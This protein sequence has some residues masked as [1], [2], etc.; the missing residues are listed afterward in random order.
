[1]SAT[2][3]ENMEGS[4]CIHNTKISD[5]GYSN[6]CSNSKSQRSGSSKTHHSGSSGAGSSGCSGTGNTQPDTPA[7]SLHHAKDKDRKTKEKEQKTL[8][9]SSP[10]GVLVDETRCKAKPCPSTAM[11]VCLETEASGHH[12]DEPKDRLPIERT[13]DVLK[14]ETQTSQDSIR[15]TD[16]KQSPYCL[17]GPSPAACTAVLQDDGY[18]NLDCEELPAAIQVQS[19]DAITPSVAARPPNTED[20][21]RCIIS[22]HDG[23]V[24]FTTPSITHSL[25]FP[26][27]MW[28]GRSFIDFVHPKDRATFAS[29]IT[30]KMAVPLGALEDDSRQKCQLNSLYVMLRKYRG[31]KSAGFAVTGTAVNY[32]PYR[33][34]LTFREALEETS[35]IAQRT[36]RNILLIISATPVKSVYKM[37]NEK[38]KDKELKFST[39]HKPCGR[40]NYVDGSSVELLGY[41]PQDIIERS[42]MELYHPEDMPILKQAYEKV[43]LNG[44]TVGATFA[45]PPYRFL[46]QNDCY[47]IL[48]TEWTSFVN[49]WSRMLELIIG[50]HRVLEGPFNPDVFAPSEGDVNRE[51]FSNEQM[52]DRESIADDIL[53]LLKEP[54]AKPPDKVSQEV[55]KR[56]Q[57]LASLMDEIPAEVTKPELTLNLLKV[58]SELTFSEQDSVM[59]GEISPHHDYFDSKSSSETPPSYHQLNYNDNLYRF[60]NSHPIMNIEESLKIDSS[61]G[62]NTE[63]IDGQTNVSPNRQFSGSGEGSNDSSERNGR[64]PETTPPSSNG[65]D[66]SSS[67]QP[68]ALTEEMLCLHDEDM[69]KAMLKRHREA[70]TLAR[71]SEKKKGP[72]D[73]AQSSFVSHGLKRGLSNSWEGDNH[74][75]FKHQHNPNPTANGQ[76]QSLYISAPPNPTPLQTAPVAGP[77]A[78][79]VPTTGTIVAPQPTT[80]TYSVPRNGDQWQPFSVSLTTIQTSHRNTTASFVPSQNMLP[81]LY[82]IPTVPQSITPNP[83]GILPRI[84]TISIPYIPDMTYPQPMQL[85]QPSLYYSPMMYQAMPFQPITLPS[86][87]T[88]SSRNQQPQN[89]PPQPQPTAQPPT[90]SKCCQLNR[91]TDAT[92]TATVAN[93]GKQNDRVNNKQCSLYR[94]AVDQFTT[95]SKGSKKVFGSFTDISHTGENFHRTAD[96]EKLQ[97]AVIDDTRKVPVTHRQASEDADESTFSSLASSFLRTENTSESNCVGRKGSSEMIWESAQN[98]RRPEPPWMENVSQTTNWAYRYQISDRVAK[99]VLAADLVKLKGLKQPKLVNDQL[100]QLYLDLELQGLSVKLSLSEASQ[101]HSTSSSDDCDTVDPKKIAK[102]NMQYNKLQFIYEEN[103]PFPPSTIGA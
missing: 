46:A 74:K 80:L 56:C 6:S 20:G 99:D 88:N 103:A 19:P 68:P 1:M 63:T 83:G 44:Q 93:G 75:T 92:G 86:G 48:Q 96:E 36:G 98:S 43:M 40:L 54:I 61:G 3:T 53:Q 71:S 101:S 81:T 69:Q 67:F 8:I 13:D 38:L 89:Q 76:D 82:Y 79:K 102:R 10:V 84:N 45:S 41:L 14:E 11:T 22:M 5:S 42:I 9:D 66:F 85:Y 60:F 100:G 7:A 52:K 72:P 23:V 29:Q 15:R 95:V 37:P 70:R 97:N 31:L 35:D 59:L 32:E 25:G 2:G 30:S 17:P 34:V 57:L 12:L 87:L 47:I 28:I 77:S 78:T 94:T 4:E 58:N 55:I 49:P 21:F 27:N 39:I 64:M 51:N 18:H 33:L 26:K 16:T 50:N 91:P 90:N 73:K 24:L 62:A 65:Q